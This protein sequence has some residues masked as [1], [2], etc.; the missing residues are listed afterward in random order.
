MQKV[1]LIQK[2]GIPGIDLGGEE[3]FFEETE[4]ER[5]V[6]NITL[7]EELG[8]GAFAI[9]YKG[10]DSANRDIAVKEIPRSRL[11]E[12]LL[13]SLRK[14]VN[15]LRSLD[16]ENIV[17]LY[18]VIKTP[19]HYYLVM[20]FCN[21]GDLGKLLKKSKRFDEHIVQNIVY[22][23]ANGL[24][25]LHQNHIIHRDLKLSN[26]LLKSTPTKTYVVKIAD[27]GFATVLASGQ[28]AETFCGTAPNMA[29]EVLSGYFFP[30]FKD[31][32]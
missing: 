4:T 11:S 30:H 5:K 23:I 3:E 15:I 7:F 8:R 22:Q 24:K 14:E 31:H 9:V 17:K 12:K 13:G 19:R 27:F 18:D 26:F 29:P 6:G 16:C 20:E 28:D 25:V 1:E 2:D 21:G 32:Q 10:R